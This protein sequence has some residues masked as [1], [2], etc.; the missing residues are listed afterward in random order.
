MKRIAL[1]PAVLAA[2]LPLAATSA[3]AQPAPAPPRAEP[4]T[5]PWPTEPGVSQL[6]HVTLVAASKTGGGAAQGNL[7]KGVAK[8]LDDIKDF[9]PYQSY[10]VVDSALV[11]ASREAHPRLQGPDGWSYQAD[12][13]FREAPQEGGVRSFLVEHF[14]LSRMPR[15]ADLERM[16][17]GDRPGRAVAPLAP[18]PN[19]TA[20]FRIAKG[21]TVV[22]GSSRLD[23]GDDALIVLLTAVP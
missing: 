21:E 19:L 8:A 4:R 3:F 11:R 20:S 9:L 2:L 1:A 5:T 12:I 13:L 23:G 22:V 18:E 14:E 15:M 10:R 16:V 7:P 6:F 17:A